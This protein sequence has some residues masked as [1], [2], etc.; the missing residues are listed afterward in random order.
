MESDKFTFEVSLKDKPNTRRGILSLTSSVY[1]PLGFLAPI[2]LPANKLLQDLCRQKLGWDDP[3]GD[4]ECQRWEK[5]KE[6]LPNLLQIAV[7]RCIKPPEFGDLKFAELHS[8]ADTSQIAYG[9]V[10]Y[11][12][13][14][15]VEDR[16]HCTFLMGKSHLAHLKPMTVPRMELSAAVLAVQLDK[17]LR[18]ELDIPIAQS[19]FWS[20]STCVIQYI[21]SEMSM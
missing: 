1:H 17:S 7:T 13:L 15:D 4:S 3:V 12:R 19:T 16:I 9:A 14:V 6:Q 10:S 11:L 18:E 21:R 20:D 8:F 2:V 5:W